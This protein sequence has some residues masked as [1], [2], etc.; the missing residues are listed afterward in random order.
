MQ[1]WS[2]PGPQAGYLANACDAKNNIL[3]ME[4]RGMPVISE[5]RDPYA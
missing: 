1:A 2:P 4:E 5:S 3:A